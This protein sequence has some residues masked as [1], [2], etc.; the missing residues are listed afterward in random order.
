M[1]LYGKNVTKREGHWILS[2]KVQSLV[3]LNQQTVL[4]IHLP[5]FT[6]ILLQ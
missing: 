5:D 2:L 4:A 3:L 1:A 6:Y